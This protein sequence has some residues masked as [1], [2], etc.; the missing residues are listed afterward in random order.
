MHSSNGHKV[1]IGAESECHSTE[2][3]EEVSV[4][5][6][7]RARCR[8]EVHVAS[9]LV[10]TG[11][12]A[13]AQSCRACVGCGCHVGVGVGWCDSLGVGVCVRACLCVHRARACMQACG[14]A[15]IRA[16]VRT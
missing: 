16:G 3:Y 7:N 1:N 2:G 10:G 12:R 4:M 6:S 9:R 14:R 13:C 15:G 11:M 8:A 5:P